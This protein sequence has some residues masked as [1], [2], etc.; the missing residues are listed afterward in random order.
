MKTLIL[1]TILI[2]SALTFLSSCRTGQGSTSAQPVR[3]KGAPRGLPRPYYRSD[4][5]GSFYYT[6]G[7]VEELND[8]YRPTVTR[9]AR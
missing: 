5:E 4:A 9:N 6:R 8:N 3:A 2:A 1:L 7:D